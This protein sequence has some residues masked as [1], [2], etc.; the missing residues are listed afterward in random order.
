M[1]QWP[2][3]EGAGFP[4]EGSHVQIQWVAPRSTNQN[5]P[6]SACRPHQIHLY[7]GFFEN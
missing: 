6:K 5:L 3:S 7:R 4:I 1:E 2:S